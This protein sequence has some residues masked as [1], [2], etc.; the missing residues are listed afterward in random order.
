VSPYFCRAWSERACE[1]APSIKPEGFAVA[2]S[3]RETPVRATN[4]PIKTRR[5]KNADCE[6]DFF[7]MGDGGVEVECGTPLVA[8]ILARR[9]HIFYFFSIFSFP[10]RRSRR[11]RSSHGRSCPLSR[12]PLNKGGTVARRLL[13]ALVPHRGTALR[14]GMCVFGDSAVIGPSRTGIFR[15]SRSTYNRR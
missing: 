14:P 7:F 12:V 4:R 10:V 9:Q 11:R 8:E 1:D 2:S 6:V 13:N 3:A 5:L 15:R